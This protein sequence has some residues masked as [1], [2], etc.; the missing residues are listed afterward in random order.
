MYR[1]LSGLRDLPRSSFVFD[2]QMPSTTFVNSGA[3]AAA[4]LKG[5]EQ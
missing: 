4:S 2:E 1:T 5:Q 3:D